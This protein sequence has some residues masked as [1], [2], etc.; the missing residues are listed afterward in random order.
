M[1]ASPGCLCAIAVEL[2]QHGHANICGGHSL[3]CDTGS[4]ECPDDPAPCDHPDLNDRMTPPEA[5][6]L[7]NASVVELLPIFSSLD[8]LTGCRQIFAYEREPASCFNC[9]RPLRI[10]LTSYCRFLI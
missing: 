3:P 10:R 8:E 5:I 7:P 9:S 4:D 6:D 2:D 1:M